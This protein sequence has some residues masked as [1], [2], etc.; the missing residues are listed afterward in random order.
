MET[1]GF[2]ISKKQL[3]LVRNMKDFGDQYFQEQDIAQWNKEGGVPEEVMRT[4]QNSEFGC[5]G[6]PEW[7]GGVPCTVLTHVLLVEEM[8][9]SAG[10]ALPFPA[11]WFS[12]SLIERIASREL[13]EK[14]FLI[15]RETA[16]VGFSVALSES[17]SGSDNLSVETYTQ[18]AEDTLILNGRKMFVGDG[19][20]APFV[21]ATAAE[22]DQKQQ[23]EDK[24]SVNF[25]L[26][27]KDTQGV[28]IYPLN[29][30]GQRIIPAC[31]M[32]FEDVELDPTCIVG[33][34]EEN[35]KNLFFSFELGRI[36]VCAA[37]VGMAQA[38]L[39]DAA[40]YAADRYAFGKAIG[41]FQQIELMLTE[42]EI[43][44][45][46]MRNMLYCTAQKIDNGVDAKLDL[47]LLK[48]FVP[49]AATEI[50]SNALQIFAGIGYT[51][52]TRVGRIWTDC[53]GNQIN[54]GTDQ[55]MARNAGREI[56]KKYKS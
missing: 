28:L 16:R 47:F 32:S 18:I 19:Q 54:E 20:Y 42:M 4:Y 30:L 40:A 46:N 38:A 37:S 24:A 41:E 15:Y 39:E 13:Q 1:T 31:A 11:H 53:R 12:F 52:Q 45:M 23:D 50:A 34:R 43:A 21:L 5:L 3:K 48:K 44:L 33:N 26:F 55:I 35:R 2:S 51:D 10:A 8:S 14:L 56:L 7:C 29:K 6:L 17:H 25:L 49:A 9:R 22:H 27:P 36:T